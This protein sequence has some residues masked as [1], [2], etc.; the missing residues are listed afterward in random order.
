MHWIIKNY[1][2]TIFNLKKKINLDKKKLKYNSLEKLFNYFGTDKGSKTLLD[3]YS[4]LKK[5]SFIKGHNFAKFYDKNLKKIKNKKI[6]VLEIGVWKGASTAS[7]FYY[8]P[9]ANFISIDRNF[10]FIFFSKRINFFF[11]DTSVNNDLKKLTEFFIK[12]NVTSFDV[13]IDDS[14]HILSEILK[15]F[16][17]FFKFLKSKGIYIIE[18]YKHP[19]YFTYLN[20]KKHHFLVDKVLYF[21]KKKKLFTS[22][23]FNKKQIKYLISKVNKVLTYKGSCKSKDHKN[24]SDIAFI[25]KK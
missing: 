2:Q 13:I 11:C 6:N 1:K 24:I 7:F 10:K 15:N 8:F 5:K 4:S 20:D 22:T 25:Y 18:D 3:P 23:I 9:N 17:F 14:S 21:I 19:N 16:I 12:K